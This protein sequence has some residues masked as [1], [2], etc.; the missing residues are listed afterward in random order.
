MT[1]RNRPIL[2]RRLGELAI[3]A[4][5][6]II[7]SYIGYHA[8]T[9]DRGLNAQERLEI[10][11]AELNATL[12]ELVEERELLK[13]QIVLLRPATLD[14]DMLDEQA[15]AVLNYA[16]KGEMTILRNAR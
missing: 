16:A 3:P 12:S 6:L 11:T 10:E 14:P 7:L 4:V 8:F 5:C 1:M 9:G 13:K 15:R 2:R